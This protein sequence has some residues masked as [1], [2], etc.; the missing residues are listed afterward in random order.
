MKR[1]KAKKDKRSK[2][3]FRNDNM[4]LYLML[5]DENNIWAYN[6]FIARLTAIYNNTED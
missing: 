5:A 3:R 2:I 4:R 6:N 1:G